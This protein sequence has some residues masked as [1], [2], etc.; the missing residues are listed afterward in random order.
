MPEGSTGLEDAVVDAVANSNFKNMA[1]MG[2]LNALSH[3]NRM[4][5]L[6]ET[7]LSKAVEHVHSTSVPEGLG[8]AAAQRGD[9]AK[10]MAELLAAVKTGGNIPPVTP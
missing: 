7:L 2:I 1:E 10:L 8:I 9:V 5:I 4:N 3:Q 6:A